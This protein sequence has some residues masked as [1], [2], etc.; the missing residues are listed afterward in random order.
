MTADSAL[1]VGKSRRSK[2]QSVALELP[3][4]KR[5]MISGG[6]RTRS[7][8]FHSVHRIREVSWMETEN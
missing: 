6:A 7:W 4:R 3:I 1:A 5:I 2:S 8:L